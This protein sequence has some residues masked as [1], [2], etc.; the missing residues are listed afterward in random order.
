[1]RNQIPL[2]WI[3]AA[4]A[5]TVIAA[6]LFDRAPQPSWHDQA[7]QRVSQRLARLSAWLAP[8]YQA[9]SLALRPQPVLVRETCRRAS[10]DDER[11]RWR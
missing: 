2:Q 3:E 7:R 1:M 5:R 8:T 11:R 10:N 9:G 6:A 4:E